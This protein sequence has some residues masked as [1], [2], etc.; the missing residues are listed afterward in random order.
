M[1]PENIESLSPTGYAILG[2]LSLR[3]RS[4]YEI[5]R[6]ASRNLAWGVSD[7][8]L[9]PQLHRLAE[10]GLIE[11][12]GPP[13]ATRAR[14]CW[15]LTETGRA[16]L[17][18]WISGDTHQFLLRDENLAKILFAD[19]FGPE[20]LLDLLCRRRAMF[21]RAAAKLAAVEPGAE[22]GA[23]GRSGPLGP[24][25]AHQFGTDFIAFNLAWCDQAISA[26]GDG[27]P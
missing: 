7:G 12:A 24:R 4:G 21:E 20:A 17:G 13:E 11:P 9:Y 6:A 3:E 25:L 10:H 23:E 19:Q 18:R 26:L 16:A 8:Q 15:R 14:Q 1:E 2:Y 5:R 22:R 27:Q